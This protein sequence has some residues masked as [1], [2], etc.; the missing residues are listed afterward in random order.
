MK[1]MNFE[2]LYCQIFNSSI[3]AI[4]ITDL[5]G[6]YTTVN[7]AWAKYLGYTEEEARKLCVQD[8]TPIE[9]R[10]TSE[11]N[12][13]RL[14]NQQTRSIR[15][16]RRYLRKDGQIFWADLHVTVLYD[17]CDE[18]GCILGMFVNIDPQRKAEINLE[19]LNAQ[20]TMANN[21]LQIAMRKLRAMA[22]KDPLTKL[23]NRRVLEEV[24]ESEIQRSFRSNRGLGVAIGDIDDFKEINDTFGHECGDTVLKNLAQVLRSQIRTADTVGRWGGEEFLFIFSE[25]SCKGAMI[26][27]ERIRKAVADIRINCSGQEISLTMSIGLSYQSDKPQ[28]NSIISEAD[29]AL[30]MAKNDGKNRAYCFQELEF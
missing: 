21:E 26:V 18:S 20:L 3:V 10:E 12:F 2:A 16:T 4:G 17:G 25:T 1:S 5:E 13:S 24:I 6:R 15:T 19:N 28:R 9:D 11:L 27:V 22:R 14:V 29:K 8:V 30:Y 7:P 23:Y